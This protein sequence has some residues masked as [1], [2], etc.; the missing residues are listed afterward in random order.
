MGI[1]NVIPGVSGGTLAVILGIYD[2]F[3]S[4]LSHIFKKFKESVLF[5]IPVALGM[6]FAIIFSSKVIGDAFEYFPLATALLFEGMI[7]GGIPILYKKIDGHVKKPSNILIFVIVA[8]ALLAYTFLANT[9]NVVNITT[10]GLGEYLILFVM[11][12]ISAATMIIPGISGSMTLMVFGYYEL[13][14]SETIG[15]ILDFSKFGYHM[16]ILIPF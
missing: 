6:V 5:L 1:G 14:V 4:S 10:F 16:Q 11:G 8:G 7:L 13:I 15:T 12:I 9:D 2:K 3:I